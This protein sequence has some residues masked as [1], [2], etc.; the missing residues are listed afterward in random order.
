MLKIIPSVKLESY[1][2]CQKIFLVAR[3]ILEEE[4]HLADE[5]KIVTRIEQQYS[6]QIFFDNDENP[7]IRLSIDEERRALIITIVEQERSNY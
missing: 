6:P 2:T 5:N 4:T 1:L 3:S 7:M